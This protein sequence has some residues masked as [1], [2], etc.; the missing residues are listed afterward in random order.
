[1]FIG[2]KN[3]LQCQNFYSVCTFHDLFTW[4][5]YELLCHIKCTCV[6][7]NLTLDIFQS[8]EYLLPYFF[9]WRWRWW[10]TISVENA[11]RNWKL[12]NVL[13]A[14]NVTCY[15]KAVTPI[16]TVSSQHCPSVI[17]YQLWTIKGT[18]CSIFYKYESQSHYKL[19]YDKSV[20]TDLM[21]ITIDW[22]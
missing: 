21:S 20:V 1:M 7:S 9:L 14:Y 11:N 10:L 17:G 5:I 8:S 19:Y 2:E 15:L 12:L 13:L 4:I 18:T 16:V 22:T 6:W 3:G